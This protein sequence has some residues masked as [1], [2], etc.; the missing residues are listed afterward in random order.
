MMK[1]DIN[2]ILFSEECIQNRIQ[3]LA[4]MINEDYKNK[5]LMLVCI[6]KGSIMFMG[7]LM[8]K[9]NLYTVVEFMCV[10]SYGNSTTS[11]GNVRI[12]KDLDMPVN[13]KH[14]VIVEDII[15]TGTT[16]KYVKEYLL[17]KGAES[18]EI[19]TL[20]DKPSGRK[21][22][23]DAKYVGF[24]VGNEFVIGYGLDYAEKYRN[25]PYIGILNENM[26]KS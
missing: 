3:E 14:I 19:I 4:N 16:L 23:I 25:L 5:D 9:I 18:V 6:L 22:D 7:D 8:K 20:L 12:L 10:S 17:G 1:N 15:D 2:K 13:N 26:Y 11:T 24:E 21:V